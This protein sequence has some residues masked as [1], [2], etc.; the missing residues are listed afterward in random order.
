VSVWAAVPVSI[1]SGVTRRP[2]RVGATESTLALAGAAPTASMVRV[3][4]IASRPAS[5][6]EMREW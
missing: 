5:D 2:T 6:R 3:I 1:E 4:S